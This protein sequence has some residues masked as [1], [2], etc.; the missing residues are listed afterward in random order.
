MSKICKK[1][2]ESI[3]TI[4]LSTIIIFL[5]IH[6]AP[7]DPVLSIYG[8]GS[9]IAAS[10]GQQLEMR[11]EQIR[12]ELGLN[13]SLCIQYIKWLGDLARLD[14]GDSIRTGRTVVDELF[15]HLPATLLL[16]VVSLILQ[17]LIGLIFGI[18]SAFRAQSIVDN[19]TRFICVLFSSIPGFVVGL[20]LLSFCTITLGIYK[21]G[22]GISFL[23]IIPPALTI[24]VGLAPQTVRVVRASMLSELGQQYI[25]AARAR[26]MGKGVILKNAFRNS[27]LSFITSI[28]FSFASLLGGSAVI[29]SIFAW[30]GIGKYALDSILVH[31][32]PVVQGYALIMVILVVATNAA[33][34]LLNMLFDPR[35]RDQGGKVTNEKA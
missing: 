1:I 34:D 31:D 32:Y 27:A 17:I 14:L 8:H 15:S 22:N 16:A 21:M 2:A 25:L 23:Q 29:E 9:E 35:L 10:S 7:G 28:S 12:T 5:L 20:G 19:T 3:L 4:F 18:L 30:P 26:G 33:V 24:S 6:L 11:L 13:D